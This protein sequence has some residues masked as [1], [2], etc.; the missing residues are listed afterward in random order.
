MKTDKIRAGLTV[1]ICLF[2]IMSMA[3]AR[4][5]VSAENGETIVDVDSIRKGTDGLVYYEYI[6]EDIYLTAAY[7]CKNG[8]EYD[9]ADDDWRSKGVKTRPNSGSYYVMKFVCS[10]VR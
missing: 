1:G 4:N 5:W 2:F 7:D 9:M 10:R 8:I 3:H 6:F